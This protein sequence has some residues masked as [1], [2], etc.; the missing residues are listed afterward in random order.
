M[1]SR[2]HFGIQTFVFVQVLEQKGRQESYIIQEPHYL[3]HIL[4]L[5]ALITG[6]FSKLLLLVV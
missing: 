3:S 6:A 2:F 1:S 4:S 5:G